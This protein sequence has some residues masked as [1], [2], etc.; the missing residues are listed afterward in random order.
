MS[1][2]AYLRHAWPTELPWTHFPA[3]ERRDAKTGAKL[4]A[5]GLA[6]GW[7]DFILLLPNGQAGFIELKAA[8]G[9][10]SEPQ[11]EFRS[12]AIALRCAFAT[13][14][15]LEEVEATCVR[16]LQAFNLAPRARL[17]A[18]RVAA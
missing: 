12:K 7:P 6:A 5:M 3:G 18:G 10:M 17:T 11:V 8:D 13:C 4:K 2:A 16:W 15:S 9:A 14:R 1:A